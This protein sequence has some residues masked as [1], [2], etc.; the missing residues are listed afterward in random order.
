[1]TDVVN[2][3]LE[4]IQVKLN[5]PVLV[6]AI[7][8]EFLRLNSNEDRIILDEFI[9]STVQDFSTAINVQ[10][11]VEQSTAA[12]IDLRKTSNVRISDIKIPAEDLEFK[13]ANDV[14]QKIFAQINILQTNKAISSK[15]LAIL[16]RAKAYL[17]SL[18]KAITQFI[19]DLSIC[20][21]LFQHLSERERFVQNY[22]TDI[23]SIITVIQGNM[24]ELSSIEE[25]V[26]K[27]NLNILLR[28][29]SAIRMLSRYK[30][31]DHES[32]RRQSEGYKHVNDDFN[33]EDVSE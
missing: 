3:T 24:T 4:Q 9:S 15:Y 30:E 13:T 31:F 14:E 33:L 7:K 20:P 10:F 21:S 6:S 29:D 23:D 25:K 8:A 26:I 2:D 11:L 1:V 18:K 19:K 32:N 17:T 16:T 28:S 12:I 5:L 22:V 27:S